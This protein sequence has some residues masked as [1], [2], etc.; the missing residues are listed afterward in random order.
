MLITIAEIGQLISSTDNIE[1]EEFVKTLIFYFP[2]KMLLLLRY[3]W[4][5]KSPLLQVNQRIQF[6]IT[7][8]L[9]REHHE[10]RQQSCVLLPNYEAI[11]MVSSHFQSPNIIIYYR[12]CLQDDEHHPRSRFPIL[13]N[14]VTNS[15]RLEKIEALNSLA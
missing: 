2:H 10:S 12:Q 8:D 14:I 1:S 4:P 3:L 15:E 6:L 9:T 5:M 7:V 13:L 11:W